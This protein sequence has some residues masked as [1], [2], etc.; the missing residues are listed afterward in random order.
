MAAARSCGVYPPTIT[1]FESAQKG[2]LFRP[3]HV[4]FEGQETESKSRSTR[5]SSTRYVSTAHRRTPFAM[6]VPHR[7]SAY[8]MAVPRTAEH[9]TLWPHRAG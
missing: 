2:A 1:A 6:T 8:D 4:T 7:M 5:S 3:A 9:H